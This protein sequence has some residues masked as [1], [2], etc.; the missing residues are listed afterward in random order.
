MPTIYG[1][2]TPAERTLIRNALAL[3]AEARERAGEWSDDEEELREEIV[4]ELEREQAAE[5]GP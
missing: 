4:A 2:C 1:T 3:Y 5:D